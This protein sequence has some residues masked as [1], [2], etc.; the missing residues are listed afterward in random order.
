LV[1][2][3]VFQG[4]ADG[5]AGLGTFGHGYTY[6][7]HPVPAAVAVETL[8]IYDEMN[9][10]EHVGKVAPSLQDGLRSRFGDHPLVGE[11]RGVGLIG[12]VEFVANK[13]TR[14]NFDPAQKIAARLVKIAEG[15]GLIM[16]ALPGDGIAFSPPLIITEE[17]VNDM[18]DR[19]GNALDELTV[20]MRRESLAAV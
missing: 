19:F 6:S 15:Q 8:K 11:I 14:A 12:A 17:E 18:L 10:V 1:N 13:E 5:S 9:L 2:D 7:G 3:R 16:R 4:L 20:Q